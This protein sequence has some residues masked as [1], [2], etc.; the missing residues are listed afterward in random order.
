MMPVLMAMTII[1]RSSEINIVPDINDGWM[2]IIVRK[3]SKSTFGANKST[4]IITLMMVMV[5][6]VMVVW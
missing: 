1:T 6:I 2:V 5:V 3:Y 4:I